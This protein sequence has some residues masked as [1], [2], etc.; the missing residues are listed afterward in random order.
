MFVMRAV[1]PDD[2]KALLA[3]AGNVGSGMT[4]F[5]PN[6]QA[7]SE[8]IEIAVQSF[9]GRIPPEQADF[10]FALEDIDTGD[11][12][13][14]SALKAM[15]GQQDAFYN[16][17]LGNTVHAS[18]KLG[19]YSNKQTL[20]LSNDLT[21]CGELC[22]LFL[23][24]RYRN[25]ENG[26]LL[27]K[28]R[29]LFAATHLHVLPDM[30]IAELRGFQREDGTSPFW[31]SLGRHF[32]QMSFEEA[33]DICGSGT[34]SFIAELMPT[35]PVYSDFLTEEGRQAIGVVHPG[36]KPAYQLLQQEGFSF[37][38]YVDIFDAGPVLQV[39]TREV[40]MVRETREV[41]VRGAT[42]TAP[43]STSETE[44]HLITNTDTEDFRAVVLPIA[45]GSETVF[46]LQPQ[47]DALH[48]NDG[49]H[50]FVSPLHPALKRD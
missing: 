12:V 31:E 2:L 21:G 41:I 34:K 38:G 40:R 10:L 23:D 48:L 50:A 20:F 45:F 42:S 33:D 46:L 30:L 17:R 16:F 15:V 28:A 47:L 13:G 49:D 22:S 32:F 39:R 44:M 7:L 8:R 36:S 35:Y 11:V 9:A 18:R 24:P 25:G 37:E 26:R 6:E 4:T 43:T 19:I 1:C 3:L 27:S 5:K 29:L 14:V